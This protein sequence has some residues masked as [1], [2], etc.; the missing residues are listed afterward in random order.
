MYSATIHRN[1]TAISPSTILELMYCSVRPSFSCSSGFDFSSAK[2]RVR[3]DIRLLRILNNVFAAPTNMPP[4]AIGRTMKRQIAVDIP[5]QFVVSVP[6]GNKCAKSGPMKYTSMGTITH[7]AKMP[8]E[9]C[10]AASFKP[11]I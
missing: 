6:A 7:Q 4:T 5:V 3:P 2:A 9:N 11:M 10:S 8:P 1:I